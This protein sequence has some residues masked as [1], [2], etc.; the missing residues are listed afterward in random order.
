MAIYSDDSG[1]PGTSLEVLTLASTIDTS[2]NTVTDFTSSGLLLSPNTTYWVYIE[3]PPDISQR[4]SGV[5]SHAEDTG[6]AA[7]W[8][9]G[10]GSVYYSRS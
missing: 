8:S 6:G 5:R 7:M 1:S 2:T 9:L 4:I 10:N 3:D